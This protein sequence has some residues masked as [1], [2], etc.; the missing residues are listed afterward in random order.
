MND[1]DDDVTNDFQIKG[2]NIRP[3]P[4]KGLFKEN[5]VI[6]DGHLIAI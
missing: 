3:L 4:S 1:D 5:S 2:I 6:F